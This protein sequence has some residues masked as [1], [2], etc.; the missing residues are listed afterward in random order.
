[1]HVFV[2]IWA[3]YSIFI[4]AYILCLLGYDFHVLNNAFLVH[5]PGIKTE[6]EGE[7]KQ[8]AQKS[9]LKLLFS[10]QFGRRNQRSPASAPDR[11]S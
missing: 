6:E 8:Y 10:H 4:Q 2:L 9:S 11:E 3:N 7:I 1:M 5:K